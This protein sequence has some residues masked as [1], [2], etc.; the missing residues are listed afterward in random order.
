MINKFHVPSPITLNLFS[1]PAP[2]R[3]YIFDL[4]FP[5]WLSTLSCDFMHFIFLDIL[6][7]LLGHLPSLTLKTHN[8][9]KHNSELKFNH[10]TFHKITVMLN[11]LCKVFLYIH[12]YIQS[13][14]I[15]LIE[16]R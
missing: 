4:F 2:G 8:T 12:H 11:E 9:S 3:K 14:C 15:L 13:L 10:N 7:T 5:T 1:I 6:P 16:I